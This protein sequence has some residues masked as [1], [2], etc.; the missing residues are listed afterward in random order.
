VIPTA[1]VV[2]LHLLYPVLISVPLDAIHS[3]SMILNVMKPVTTLIATMMV[4]TAL[5][6][7]PPM[8]MKRLLQIQMKNL[9]AMGVVL[10]QVQIL[11]VTAA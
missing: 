7:P 9:T 6:L 3:G 8:M 5:H 2:S 1:L 10:L 4:M 11:I